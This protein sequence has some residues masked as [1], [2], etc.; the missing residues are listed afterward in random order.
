M[1]QYPTLDQ[2]YIVLSG[3]DYTPPECRS[4]AVSGI[5]AGNPK[6]KNGHI[7]TSTIKGIDLRTMR[8]QTRNRVYQLLNPLPEFLKMVKEH[9]GSLANYIK[10]CKLDIQI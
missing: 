9:N 2:W 4:V 10:G 6:G 3:D 5:A 8:L 1:N 7:T